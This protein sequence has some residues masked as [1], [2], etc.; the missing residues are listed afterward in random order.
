M[1]DKKKPPPKDEPTPFEKFR[2]L[3]KRVMNAPKP[4]P[5]PKSGS[6]RSPA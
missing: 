1:R 5:D 3:A 6:R 4:P 2:A